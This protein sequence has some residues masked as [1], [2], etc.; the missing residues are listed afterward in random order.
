MWRSSEHRLAGFISDLLSIEGRRERYE[1]QVICE[2][3]HLT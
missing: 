2:V 1:N 3:F